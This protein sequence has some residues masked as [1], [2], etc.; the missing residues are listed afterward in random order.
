MKRALATRLAALAGFDD[1]D[2]ELE[3]YPTSPEL[4]ANL[5]HLADLTGDLDGVVVD[6]GTGTGML[7]LAVATRNPE[8]VIGLDVD[9]DALDTALQN[10]ALVD[11][12]NSVDWI[13]ADASRPPVARTDATVVMN[14][15]FG[16]QH[17]NRG[18]DR[19]FLDAARSIAIVTYSI[20]NAGSREFIE[21]YADD[22]DGTVT[23]AF[24]AE[25]P[26]EGQFEFHTSDR[27]DLPVEAFRIEWPGYPSS[28]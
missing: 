26:I 12:P 22:H 20:H 24:A 7:A 21:S 2:V 3:Q 4:A 10:E 18:A 19:E 25:L 13:Q 5:V 17:G 6:L 16:A 28:G 27:A 9:Q 1:P 8:R 23:H 15:P 11:P 14:P